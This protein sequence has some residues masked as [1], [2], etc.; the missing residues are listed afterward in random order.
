MKRRKFIKLI[1]G[2]AVA[3]PL[4]SRRQQAGRIMTSFELDLAI[5][6]FVLL[7]IVNPCGSVVAG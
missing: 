4:I 1:G 2:A 6:A 7:A 5:S 3:W